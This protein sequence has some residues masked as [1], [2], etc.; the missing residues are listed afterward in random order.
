MTESDP[1][2]IEEIVP[3]ILKDYSDEP[4][5]W[6]ILSTP[7]GDMLVLGP[8]STFQLKLIPLGPQKFTGAG[9]EISEPKK[10]VK[11][12]K[13]TPEF[14][15]RPLSSDDMTELLSAFA[16]PETS[17]SNIQSILSRTPLSHD[18]LTQ[19]SAEH[20]LSGPILTRP[21]FGTLDSEILKRQLSLDRSASDVFRR[22]YP[23]RSGMYF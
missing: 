15:L 17:G 22:R 6:R 19:S 4:R 1:E 12:I 13:Q 7:V 16:H 9:V 18:D 5:G 8:T 2:P 10:A 21:D 20:I 14:G 11:R 3:R 23:M